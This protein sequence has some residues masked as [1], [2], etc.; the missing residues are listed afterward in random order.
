MSLMVPSSQ[1]AGCRVQCA[2]DFFAWAL[3]ATLEP[4]TLNLQDGTRKK[5]TMP[6]L[7]VLAT[8]LRSQTL[9]PQL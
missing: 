8:Y 2:W 9:T 3:D 6:V 4:T 5:Q 1:F 7:V